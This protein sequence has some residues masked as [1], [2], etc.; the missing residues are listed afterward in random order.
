M[1]VHLT[2]Y[3]EPI[4]ERIEEIKKERDI[5]VIVGA[6]KVPREVFDLADY[7]I[8]IG[9]QPHSEVAALAIFLDRYTEGGWQNKKF[10]GEMEIVPMKKG[11]RV[12]RRKKLPSEKECI[13]I[14]RKEGCSGEV[15]RHSIAVK[16][17]AVKIAKLA[18]ADVD[19][20]KVGALLHDVGRAVT[21]GIYHGIE[22]AKI[23]RKL[24]LPREVVNIIERHLGAGITKKEARK[25]GLPVKDYTPRTLEEKIVAHA[26]NLIDGNRKQK[27]E[28]EIDRQLKKGNK[29]YAE[30]LRRLH[31]ELSEACGIDLDEI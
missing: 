13:E 30:R 1:K 10:E 24:S 14:L 29:E 17:L 31:D 15:I 6:E 7:N 12:V 11:K 2:M 19:L 27:I 25:L 26:D 28:E 16:D 22:G 5:L 8:A 4:K 3:G 23:A 18:N 21:H 20:V 9:N